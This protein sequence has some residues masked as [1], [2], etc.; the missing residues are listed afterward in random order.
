[1][2]DLKNC[3][4]IPFLRPYLPQCPNINK[5]ITLDKL[6]DLKWKTIKV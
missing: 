4:G 1:M 2:G 5:Y 6:I 3:K